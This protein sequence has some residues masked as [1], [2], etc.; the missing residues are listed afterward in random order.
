MYWVKICQKRFGHWSP[1]VSRSQT[2]EGLNLPLRDFH[3]PRTAKTN[4]LACTRTSVTVQERGEKK[5][6]E[7]PKASNIDRLYG[8]R[9]GGSS[10]R[11]GPFL[12]GTDPWAI[13]RFWLEWQNAILT[14]SMFQLLSS[15]TSRGQ[16]PKWP[17]IA[18]WLDSGWESGSMVRIAAIQGCSQ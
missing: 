9:L 3:Q 1:L 6:K 15:V 17:K 7:M 2:A 5:S 14:T 10:H 4:L 8:Q 16:I 12:Q 18:S 13:P 11:V